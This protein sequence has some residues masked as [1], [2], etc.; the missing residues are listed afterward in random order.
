MQA[1]IKEV[2]DN[3][4]RRSCSCKISNHAP[5]SRSVEATGA[6]VTLIGRPLLHL[7]GEAKRL[8]LAFHIQWRIRMTKL[9]VLSAALIATAM[10]ATPALARTSH[11]ASSRN[12]AE[13]TDASAFPAVRYADGRVCIPAPRVGSFATA[14][15][16]DTNVPCEPEAY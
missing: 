14:P 2:I 11:V 6:N 16:S 3:A 7:H 13:D 12:L 15:W 8:L 4:Q 10:L 5:T 1:H 9:K